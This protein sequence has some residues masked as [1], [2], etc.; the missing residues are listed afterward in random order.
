MSHPTKQAKDIRALASGIPEK[1]HT[2]QSLTMFI[3]PSSFP[4]V[5][6]QESHRNRRG[7]KPNN[8]WKSMRLNQASRFATRLTRKPSNQPIITNSTRV[9]PRPR[10]PHRIFQ[11]P[12]QLGWRWRA[13]CFSDSAVSMRRAHSYGGTVPWSKECLHRRC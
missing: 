8:R 9:G 3:P 7:H 10:V 1:I 13:L 4:A 6:L 12:A 5:R 11:P 2:L